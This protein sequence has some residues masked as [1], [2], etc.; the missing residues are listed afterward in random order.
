MLALAIAAVSCTEKEN[1]GTGEQPVAKMKGMYYAQVVSDEE[2]IEVTPGKTKTIGVRAIA[3]TLNGSVSDIKLTLSFKGD[4]AA[5]AAYNS[6]HGTSYEP[7]PG[8]SYEFVTNE[9]MMPRYGVTSTT[10]KLKLSSAGLEDGVTYV[11][12]VVVDNVVETDNWELSAK[13]YAYVVFKLAYVAPNAGSGT[14]EDPF[15]LY[16]VDDLLKMRTQLEAKKVIYFRLQNDIDMAGVKGWEP[17]NWESPYEYGIDFDG[18]NHTISNFYCDFASYPSFFGVLNGKCHDFTLANA[19]VVVNDA[20]SGILAGYCGLQ[21]ATK[22]IRGDCERV[23][24]QGEL[25]HTAST[26]YGAGGFFGFMGTGSLKACSADV[27]IN[28]KL[29]NV[30]GL[31]GYCGKVVEV[32]DCWTTGVITGAQRVGGI[33]GG[34]VGDDDPSVPI[35]IVNCYSTAK[36]HGS[37]AIGGIGGFFNK[38]S[39]TK[40]SPKDLDLGNVFENC[41]AWNEEIRA[42]SPYKDDGTLGVPTAGDVSHYSCGAIIGYT[43]LKNSLRGCLRNPSMKYNEVGFFD[44][45]DA[46]SLYDQNNSSSG[47]PLVVAEV[48]DASYNYPYHG[49]A[50][51]AGKTLS[52]IAKSLGWSASVWDFSGDTPVLKKITSGEDN[53]DVDAGGQLPDFDENDFYN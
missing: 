47:A 28:S 32:E 26:K 29:N 35:K 38:A 50:A 53:S 8:T 27:I 30:G 14:K 6:A 1:G 37:F 33:G 46:F 41:I 22:G 20:R 44:Y 2:V 18:N 13:P 51:P 15:N 23:H 36:V 17:L 42:N 7:C 34:T 39:T 52:Q 12:P 9:V 25:D 11:L 4:A 45:S 24:I 21:D 5:V 48:A 19:K 40:G 3:D 31:F 49:K 16:T 10:A 43:A